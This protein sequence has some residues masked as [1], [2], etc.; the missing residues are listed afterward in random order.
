VGELTR[1]VLVDSGGKEFG[2]HSAVEIANLHVNQLKKYQCFE[3]SFVPER[4]TYNPGK[5]KTL[6]PK[7]YKTICNGTTITLA[8]SRSHDVSGWGPGLTIEWELNA[9]AAEQREAA[10]IKRL[11]GIYKDG[12]VADRNSQVKRHNDDCVS[13]QKDYEKEISKWQ[14]DCA[15]VGKRNNEACRMCR[16]SRQVAC[17]GGCGASKCKKCGGSRK[18]ACKWPTC[19]LQHK[20]EKEPKE[21]REPNMPSPPSFGDLGQVVQQ[22]IESL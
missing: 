12:V 13:K 5:S 10:E 8:C 22:Y 16:G 15:A 7:A 2:N 1:K 18:V 20:P 14:R 6:Q 11:A 9:S 3:V 17:G 4:L 21:P 19:P